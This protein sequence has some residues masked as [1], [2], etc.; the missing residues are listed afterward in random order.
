MKKS[1]FNDYKYFLYGLM[2]S[3]AKTN[4]GNGGLTPYYSRPA[5]TKEQ[6]ENSYGGNGLNI[7]AHFN[8]KIT[9]N[10]DLDPLPVPDPSSTTGIGAAAAAIAEV[11]RNQSP[12]WKY[13]MHYENDGQ[14]T[15][16]SSGWADC[17]SFVSRIYH[18]LIPD[19][20]SFNSNSATAGLAIISPGVYNANYVLPASGGSSK[21]TGSL[22]KW[23]NDNNACVCCCTFDNTVAQP[24]DVILYG[25]KEGGR[26]SESF[27]SYHAALYVGNNQVIDESDSGITKHS[28]DSALRSN[29]NKF[30]I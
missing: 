8:I 13:T 20:T 24:G 10:T 14:P 21:N 30:V 4:F 16:E 29:P 18:A 5:L 11:M 15:R 23:F 2:T 12:A 1:T 19:D 3:G 7:G 27:G 9:T 17:S 6:A 28:Y 26:Y 22:F 25:K